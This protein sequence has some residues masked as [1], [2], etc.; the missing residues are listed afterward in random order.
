M[1]SSA[2]IQKLL[3]LCSKSGLVSHGR[4]SH[5][6]I[7]KFQT[8]GLESQNRGSTQ[9]QHALT[10]SKLPESGS[11]FVYIYIYIY[12]CTHMYFQVWRGK[13]RQGHGLARLGKA[14]RAH[15]V[16]RRWRGVSPIYYVCMYICIYVYIHIYIYMYIC[17]HTHTIHVCIYIYV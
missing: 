4:F 17:I 12:M 15:E 3:A 11:T 13:V 2:G 14:R 8:E 5:I 7:T 6:N 16:A 9:R 1:L 10:M